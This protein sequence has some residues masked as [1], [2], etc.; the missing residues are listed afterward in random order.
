MRPGKFDRHL[1]ERRITNVPRPSPLKIYKESHVIHKSSSSSNLLAPVLA[2]V[3]GRAKQQQRSDPVIIYTHSPRVI[4]T[5]ARD[6]MALVQKLTGNSPTNDDVHITP[7]VQEQ[8]RSVTSETSRSDRVCGVEN[9]ESSNPDLTNISLLAPDSA[10]IFCSSGPVYR[11][12]DSVYQSQN[13]GNPISP[14][15]HEFMK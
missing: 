6:F 3:S 13:V 4:H 11:Y 12:S 8:K 15:F 9:N 7:P 2:P 10:K 5:K 14:S 1:Q